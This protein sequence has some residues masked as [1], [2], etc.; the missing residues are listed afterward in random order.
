M[1]LIGVL[2]LVIFLAILAILYLS[3]M[4]FAYFFL[5]EYASGLLHLLPLIGLIGFLLYRHFVI[6]PA[7]RRWAAL[8]HM[9]NFPREF[10]KKESADQWHR[11]FKA[12]ISSGSALTTDSDKQTDLNHC[13][14]IVEE[15]TKSKAFDDFHCAFRLTG[16]HMEIKDSTGNTITKIV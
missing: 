9:Y 8:S 10:T 4:G 7:R 12:V 11:G 13:Q 3:V 15:M 2:L 6:E 14:H 5:G 16:C 1:E